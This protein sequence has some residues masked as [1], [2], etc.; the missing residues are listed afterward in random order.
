MS[1][2]G[3]FAEGWRPEL[4]APAG[5]EDVLN[6]VLDAGADAVYLSGKQ[7]NMRRHRGDFHFD[8]AALVRGV[9]RA[10]GMGRK[11]YVTVN[12]L[13]GPDELGSLREYLAF[14][15]E[16]G[17]DAVIV[18]DLAVVGLCREVAPGLELH[19]STMMNVSCA[20]TA[21]MLG[22]WGF[23]RAV[24][25]RDITLADVRRIREVS[26]LE[27]EYFIHGDMCSVISGQCLTSGAIFGKSGNRGQCMKPCRWAYDLVSE[28]SGRVL[29]EGI[30]L[31]ASK[32][33]CL[34]QQIP[35][36]VLE[37]I[38]S[39]KIE[40]RMRPA[41]TLVPIVEAYRRAIDCCCNEPMTS[42]RRYDETDAQ[43]RARTRELTTGFAFKVP[44]GSFMDISGERE[45]VVFSK[46]GQ[47]RTQEQMTL[48][49]VDS[50]G[51]REGEVGLT[52]VVGSVE[53]AGAAVEAGCDTLIL[54]WEGTLTAQSGWCVE[55]VR[56]VV[57]L[58][59]G[60]GVAAMLRTPR[61][62]GAREAMEFGRWLALDVS[63][64]GY[65]VTSPGVL[66]MLRGRAGV[67]WADAS[68]NALNAEAAR[69]LCGQGVE[70]VMP[71]PEASLATILKLREMLPQCAVDVL[72]HGPV[73]GMLVEHC[74]IAMHTQ[75]SSKR[76]FCKMPCAMEQF[77][78]TD[79]AGTR[80][81]I[82]VDR[83]CR[84]HILLEHDVSMLPVLDVL[85]DVQPASVRIDGCTYTPELI[86]NLTSWY[87]RALNQR[88][89]LAV[90]ADAFLKEFPAELHTYGAYAKGICRDAEI[91]L[92]ELKREEQD[93][94]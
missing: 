6:A 81:R 74:L 9:A 94:S 10:H 25:S 37:G 66:R 93:A 18:Q 50:S 78:V 16:T 28:S 24:T 80:R 63:V 1:A 42:S 77:A 84:N 51:E 47:L 44:D 41:A 75:Q 21:L 60:R 48:P 54:S 11:L 68:M 5:R 23:T 61:V 55:D 45:P 71:A 39:L 38:D 36:L 67:L 86:G 89:T 2:R 82:A 43:Q 27:V 92:L 22:E 35:E 90:L 46:H 79:A 85:L 13:V 87:R 88:R 53:A 33:L 62:L 64:D 57:E 32:D 56:G 7:F 20:E 3:T 52:V 29:R 17:V 4:L 73:T 8:D 72:A 49:D 26:G 19:S 59:R 12:S 70:R 69:F 83:Y 76:D 91:S 30:H 34:L 58:A 40:G 15:A 31:L 14:L 65:V